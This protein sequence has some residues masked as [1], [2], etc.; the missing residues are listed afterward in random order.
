[1]PI[2]SMKIKV[3]QMNR[4]RAKEAG[5]TLIELLVVLAVLIALAGIVVPQLPNML[6]R[7]HSAAAST[8]IPELNKSF[9]S[10]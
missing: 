8:N 1:M 2:R 10:F 3:S 5:L 4:R 9:Q 7:S 6:T